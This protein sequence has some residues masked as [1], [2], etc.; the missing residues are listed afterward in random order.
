MITRRD[1]LR[2]SAASATAVCLPGILP[3]SVFGANAPSER[4]TLGHIGVGGQGGGLLQ[5]MMGLAEGQSLAVC[6]PIRARREDAA[7]KVNQHYAAQRGQ[8]NY[9]ACQAYAD[10]R[11]LLARK[12][13]DAVVIATPDHWHVPV[14]LAAIRAGKDVYLEKPLGLTMEQ[15]KILRAAVHGK[16]AHLV[17]VLVLFLYFAS[18][19]LWSFAY[20]LWWYGHN[21][22][23]TAAV[24]V[25][26]FM[27]PLFGARQLANFEVYSYPGLASYAM[28]VS[29]LLLIVALLVAWRQARAELAF[30]ATISSAAT[31]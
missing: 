5:G 31:R 28:G 12:D 13:I 22:D 11:E 16:M 21:L 27:P 18:F 6:D 30:T 14:A 17:D 4:V 15:D 19:S 8:G 25:D 3:S 26:P 10:F 23:P 24:K 29:A 20:K 2:V 7:K 9:Q 1:F